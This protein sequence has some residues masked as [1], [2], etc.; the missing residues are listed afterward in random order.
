M[1]PSPIP[2]I[3]QH[4]TIDTMLNNNRLRN[5]TYKQGFRSISTR[6]TYGERTHFPGASQSAG[7]ANWTSSTSAKMLQVD[8]LLRPA[9]GFV[10]TWHGAPLGSDHTLNRSGSTAPLNNLQNRSQKL[11]LRHKILVQP[12]QRVISPT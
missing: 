2:S 12:S 10:R 1:G 6:L 8:L 5:V 11:H 7:T 4:V 9:T 3:I